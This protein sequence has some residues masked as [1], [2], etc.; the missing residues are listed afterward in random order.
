[1]MSA[2]RQIRPAANVESDTSEHRE[3]ETAAEEATKGDE[4]PE[5]HVASPSSIEAFVERRLAELEVR[6]RSYVDS[7]VAKV[8]EYID[9][10]R[11]TNVQNQLVNTDHEP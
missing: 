8:L 5:E 1:M 6:M 11:G 10:K 9:K 2:L 4:E 3:E 7:K